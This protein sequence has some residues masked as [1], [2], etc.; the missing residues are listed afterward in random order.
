MDT[1][2]VCL[3]RPSSK[4]QGYGV[5]AGERALEPP[6]WMLVRAEHLRRKDV[7]V[8]AVVD[9]EVQGLGDIPEA[10]EYEIWPSGAHPSAYVQEREGVADL[11]GFLGDQRVIVK[12]QVDFP[13]TGVGPAWD[14]AD[15]RLYHTHNWHSWTGEG[16]KGYGTVHSSTS[17]PYGCSFCTV[18]D[19]YRGK[20]TVRPMWQVMNE[21]VELYD[22]GVRNIKMMDELF[23][24]GEQRLK[25]WAEG[26]M[27]CGLP[28]LN[29]WGYGRVDTLRAITD[30]TLAAAREAG[31]RWVGVGFESG[32]QG[33]RVTNGKG[34]WTNADAMTLMKRLKD[35]GIATVGNFMFG[36]PQDNRDTMRDT[37]E[38]AYALRPELANFY[39]VVPYPHTPLALFAENRHWE[40]PKTPREFAQYA[41]EFL[42][43]RTEHVDAETVLAFR[44]WA[45]QAYHRSEAYLGMLATTFGVGARSEMEKVGKVALH[46]NLLNGTW[47]VKY[48]KA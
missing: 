20:Y 22:M 46:R 45:W 37:F 35:H 15:P 39:C 41:P 11:L 1:A 31:L 32:D 40:M 16:R 13:L 17:C 7:F 25:D 48:A 33:I 4:G 28:G 6:H 36:F 14:L 12:D 9:M 24:L 30:S 2:T 5:L 38:F 43:L 47:E 27:E 10:D 18:R 23:V 19:Y 8:Q 34:G 42:P 26:V 3:I 21:I 44:D 29:V